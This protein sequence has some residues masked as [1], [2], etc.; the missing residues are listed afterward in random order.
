MRIGRVY[1]GARSLIAALKKFYGTDIELYPFNRH[2][3][4]GSGRPEDA[5]ST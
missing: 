2:P 1:A 3:K 4:T 5:S